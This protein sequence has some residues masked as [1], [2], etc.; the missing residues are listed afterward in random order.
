VKGSRILKLRLAHEAGSAA[1]PETT[2][3]AI[4]ARRAGGESIRAIARE[5]P[6]S[7]ATVQK[8]LAAA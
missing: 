6:V 4:R 1:L 5:L 2:A 8:V 3:N 7:A